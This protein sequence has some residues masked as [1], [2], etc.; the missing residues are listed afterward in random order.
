MQQLEK[1]NIVPPAD[2][3]EF[4]RRRMAGEV[5]PIH[6]GEPQAGFYRLTSKDG[7]SQPVAYWFARDGLLRC[8]IGDNDVSEQT[9]NERWPWA[10]KRP[11]SHEVY[12][13]VLA[14]GAW[15][16][17]HEAVTRDRNNSAAAPDDNSFEALQDR[18]EDLARDADALVKAGA[19]QDQ[20]AANRASDL[21]NRLG[22]LQKKA[23]AARSEERK[24]HDDAAKAVQVKW[25]PII[26]RADVYKRIKLMVITPFLQAEAK[27]QR[28]ADEAARK[29]AQEAAKA[30]SPIP[31]APVERAAPKAGS[32]GR[33]LRCPARI[34]RRDDK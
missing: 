19:A 16:D 3:C 32:G 31:E 17:Q 9:A 28:E 34:H 25:K 29:A 27:R 33:R 14:G 4:W 13:L 5:I 22:E 23:D 24:P 2:Q 26:D 11:I 7:T 12:K 30:G 6:D 8:R 1:I 15:P 20:D 18:I 10:S 21:A